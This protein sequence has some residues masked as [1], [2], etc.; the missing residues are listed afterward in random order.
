MSYDPAG[1]L[2]WYK[3]QIQKISK[4]IFV[5]QVTHAQL[6]GQPP[7]LVL[8]LKALEQSAELMEELETWKQEIGLKAIFDIE[9]VDEDELFEY[10]ELCQLQVGHLAN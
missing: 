7:F 1:D 8:H 9:Q 10:Q 2:K 3:S 5:S 6:P 4:D